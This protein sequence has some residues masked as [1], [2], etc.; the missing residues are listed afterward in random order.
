MAEFRGP[1]VR[2]PELA[3]DQQLTAPR[4]GPATQL[5]A[6]GWVNC[7][8]PVPASVVAGAPK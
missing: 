1:R 7:P 6:C 5:G 4:S 8:A 3:A 2:G